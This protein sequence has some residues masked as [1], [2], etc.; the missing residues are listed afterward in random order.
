MKFSI[1]IPTRNN[2]DDLAL[3]LKSI[4]KQSYTDEFETLVVDQSDI[5]ESEIHPTRGSCRWFRM[6]GSGVSRARNLAIRH[7]RGDYLVWVDANAQ[8][9][10]DSLQKLDK[11]IEEHPHHTAICGT[12][13]NKENGKPYSRYSFSRPRA[14]DFK[15]YDCCLA[16]AMVIKRQALEKVGLLDERLGTGTRYG[17]SEETDLVLRLLDYGEPLLYHP[18]YQVIHPALDADSMSLRVW[19][20]RHYSYG[21]GRGAMLAKH[22]RAKP[23]WACGQLGLALLKPL[24]G[25][26]IELLRLQG[27]Q[28]MRYA[29]S[30]IGR[31]YGFLSYR[32]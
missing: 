1:I 17:G 18:R 29:V 7:A 14:V 31:L 25:V 16:S 15:N 6:A 27:R 30:I 12:V 8:L 28:A 22:F 10:A 21:L 5:H 3:L 24:V 2:R 9:R 11:I 13:V 4:E 19:L 32:T 20:C 23:L 26:G